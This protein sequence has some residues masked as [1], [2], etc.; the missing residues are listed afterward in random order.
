MSNHYP[1]YERL[2]IESSPLRC[3]F[4]VRPKKGAQTLHTRRYVDSTYILYYV[5][6]GRSTV[7][8]FSSEDND[9]QC[10]QAP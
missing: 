3:V 10:A 1:G 5:R 4:D 7:Y 8:T 6:D 9:A 2:N